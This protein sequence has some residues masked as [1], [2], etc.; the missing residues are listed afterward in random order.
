VSTSAGGHGIFV[1]SCNGDA[2]N[3]GQIANNFVSIRGTGGANGI[4]VQNS[5]YQN[6]C[7]NSVNIKATGTGYALYQ[8]AGSNV[9]ILNNVLSNSAGSYAYFLNT[10]AGIT[11]SDHSPLGSHGLH[12]T[13]GPAGGKRHG[14]AFCELGS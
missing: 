10:P 4:A 6:V 2:L 1:D 3:H 7:Y 12:L 5:S 8:T 11:T 14:R 9:S 13:G